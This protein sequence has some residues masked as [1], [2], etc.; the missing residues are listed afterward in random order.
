M[1]AMFLASLVLALAHLPSGTAAL[2]T[3]AG[4]RQAAAGKAEL[5]ALFWEVSAFDSG[6]RVPRPSCTMLPVCA[7]FRRPHAIWQK[8]I[9]C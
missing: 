5:E 1:F 7:C 2:P 9:Q 6:L 4:V 8:G 3:T